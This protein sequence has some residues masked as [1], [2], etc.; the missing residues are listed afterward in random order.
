MKTTEWYPPDIQ[1]MYEGVYER[2][3]DYGIFF[4]CWIYGRW[5]SS[6]TDADQAFERRLSI[7]F[8]QNYPW[9]GLRK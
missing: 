3:E 7:A 1:P 2:D 6:S 4:S 8:R 9:R 5:G